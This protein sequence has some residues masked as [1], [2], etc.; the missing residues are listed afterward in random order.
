MFSLTIATIVLFAVSSISHA[1]KCPTVPTQ[2]DFDASKYLGLW[3]EAYRNTIIFELGS[4]CV[5]ATYTAKDDGSVGV[6][7]QAINIFGKYSSIKGS[8]RA[9]NA[10]EPAALEVKFDNQN[11]VGS[12]NVIATD[13]ENYSLVY[14]CKNIPVFGKWQFI[15]FLSR[16]KTLAPSIV[17]NLNKILSNYGIKSNSISQTHQNC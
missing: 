13:Y 4:K 5:N 8:A 12:Y 10:M 3:Y 17:D 7:N 2:K 15:W 16:T 1:G 6:W 14:S 9:K 11:Q